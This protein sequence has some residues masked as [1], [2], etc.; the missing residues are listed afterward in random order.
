MTD[1]ATYKVAVIWLLGGDTGMSS[2]SLLAAALGIAE[3]HPSYPSDTGDFGRCVRLI[4]A[5][6]AAKDGL[7]KL[8]E[9]SSYWKALAERWG[10]IEAL[11]ERD[12]KAAYELMKSILRPI[13]DG[14]RYHVSLG[15]G[16]SMRFG[17]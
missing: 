7:A 11:C 2:K 4:K 8:S 14:D 1:L 13:E 17:R 16:V 5:I 3:K 6:P 12:G 10:E 9:V 15:N